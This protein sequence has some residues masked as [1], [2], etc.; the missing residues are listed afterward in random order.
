MAW[1]ALAGTPFSDWRVPGLLLARLVGG[2]FLLAGWWQ[3][4]CLRYARE[5]SMAAGGA[6]EIASLLPGSLSESYPDRT[7]TGKRRRVYG[8]VIDHSFAETTNYYWTDRRLTH[9]GIPL[10]G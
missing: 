5:L 1:R 9:D 6:D 3:W 2:G 4:R 10:G 7:S 8:P